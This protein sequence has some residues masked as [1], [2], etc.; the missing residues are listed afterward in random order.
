MNIILF[1]DAVRFNLL[2]FTHTRPVADVR[3]GILTM[4]ERWEQ[5]LSAATGTLTEAYMQPVFSPN[6]GEDNLL[7]NG[8]VFASKELAEAVLNMELNSR[9]ERDG[10][11]IAARITTVPAA[12]DTLGD[13][14]AS[15]TM[16]EFAGEINRLEHVWDI[17]SQNDR[18]IRE[19][20]ALLTAGKKSAP[21][22]DGVLVS[23]RENLFIEEG[24]VIN[25]GVIINAATGPVYLAKDSE[26]LEGCMLRGPVALGGHA[27]LKMGAKVYGGT[28]IGEGC[29]V[30]GE[31][32]N[33]V[34]F[35]NSNKGHDGFLGNA[36]IGEWCNLGADTNCSNLKNNYDE[37]KI[38]NEHTNKSV[39]TGLQFCGLMMGDHS[40]CGIN[41]M[42]NTGTVAGVSCNIYGAGFPEK[43][44]PSFCWGS[45]DEM[46]TY[47]FNR[48][49]DT[50]GRMMARR[51]KALS[52]AELDMYRHIFQAT[53]SQ[54]KL[55]AKS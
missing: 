4:R 2:P 15:F 19:D 42:F 20:F 11:L 44:I 35:A 31:V 6:A 32:S 21:V 37:V 48:A 8:A 34:F 7:V 50:A 16:H 25:A 1:D 22:P 49:M 46:V 45:S 12:Y 41:T 36:V 43:F 27:V 13:A 51:G 55:F 3:C 28:T 47:D 24:A 53:E 39:K 30:G 52:A 9:L 17:F 18:A 29:K 38:W 10:L 26:I 33:V 23:G 40:K 5:M 54:R 14:V